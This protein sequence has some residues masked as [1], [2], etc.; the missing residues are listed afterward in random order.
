MNDDD[1]AGLLADILTEIRALRADLAGRRRPEPANILAT[2]H[3][4]VGATA[5]TSVELLNHA[6]ATGGDLRQ[7]LDG[8]SPRA[9]GKL[10]R[11]LEGRDVGGLRLERAGVERGGIVWCL[12]VCERKHTKPIGD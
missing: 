1:A 12:Q 6:Q 4:A 10:L 9:I 2:M 5:F 11:K 8:M 3:V 7:A